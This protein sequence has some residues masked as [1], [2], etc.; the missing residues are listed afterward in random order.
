MV[1]VFWVGCPD[2]GERFHAHHG[3]LRHSEYKL[4][5]PTCGNRFMD[6]ES[7]RIDE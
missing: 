5:C 2:C 4:H 7:P 3:E 6:S 1:R